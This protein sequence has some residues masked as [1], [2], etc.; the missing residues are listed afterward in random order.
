MD[1]CAWVSYIPLSLWLA[2][3]LIFRFKTTLVPDWWTKRKLVICGPNWDRF[4]EG[5][6]IDISN[7]NAT[8]MRRSSLELVPD[9]PIIL[10]LGQKSPIGQCSFISETYP[11]L[12]SCMKKKPFPSLV[13][14]MGKTDIELKT[15]NEKTWR[16]DHFWC[17][18]RNSEQGHRGN[19]RN[20][21]GR[22]HVIKL[23]INVT[24]PK[25]LP[26]II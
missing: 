1:I 19:S 24:L 13:C 2:F 18:E 14:S 6:R 21:G 25:T 23:T 16:S 26:P 11:S 9:S 20:G 17:M 12:I 3:I 22:G 8:Y 4:Y 15:G 7:G 10:Y 5:K